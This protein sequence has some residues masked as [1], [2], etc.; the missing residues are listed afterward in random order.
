MPEL[1]SKYSILKVIEQDYIL[2][3][4]KMRG[5]FINL[6]LLPTTFINRKLFRQAGIESFSYIEK[7]QYE[8]LDQMA[9]DSLS[10]FT[11]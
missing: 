4:W 1:A 8:F 11:A 5:L 3:F 9:K 6:I 2:E 7:Y 10:T